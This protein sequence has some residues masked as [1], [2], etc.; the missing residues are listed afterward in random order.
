M[1]HAERSTCPGCGAFLILPLSR[2]GK[3]QRTFLCQDCDRPDPMKADKVLAWLKSEL[4]P[5]E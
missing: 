4:R 1:G 2:G 3:G 5:P